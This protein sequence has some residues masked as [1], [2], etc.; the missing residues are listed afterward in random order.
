MDQKS[1]T[2]TPEFPPPDLLTR[3]EAAAHLRISERKLD[4]LRCEG[5]LT[6]ITLD[7]TRLVRIP[8]PYLREYIQGSEAK[9][10]V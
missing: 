10:G 9:E 6:S 2:F 5:A 7:G 8:R 4:Q 1:P 3:E